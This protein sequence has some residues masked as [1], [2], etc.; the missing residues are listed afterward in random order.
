MASTTRKKTTSKS[1]SSR[2][3]KTS[4]PPKRPV[5]REVGG[6]VLLVATLCVAVGY[7]GVHAILIDW[8]AVLLKGLF[9]Y[10]YYL[11]APAMLL[12]GL[13]LLLHRGRPV[14]LRTVCALLLPLLFGALWHTLF[15]RIVFESSV[16]I[17]PRL[18]ST[19]GELASGGVLSGV[20]AIGSVAVL[21][22]VVSAV[23]F[24]L[25]LGAAMIFLGDFWEAV[26]LAGGALTPYVPWFV[27]GAAAFLAVGYLGRLFF[28]F[29]HRQMEQEYA[30]RREVLEKTGIVLVSKNSVP[31]APSG[32]GLEALPGGGYQLTDSPALPPAASPENPESPAAPADDAEDVVD[33][34]DTDVRP[35]P[36]AK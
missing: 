5:R 22:Q 7:C 36:P 6:A 32:Q 27:G 24:V 28:V 30:F 29:R 25:L 17:L 21:S 33:V 8:L 11:A 19:G 12:A 16:G 31:L 18:W 35:A 2:G 26:R 34:D 23:F 20:L 3:K 9:G 1:G 15:C 4:P 10:G 14:V 13:V